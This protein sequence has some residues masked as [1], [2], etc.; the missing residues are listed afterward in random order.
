MFVV[1]SKN[2][3]Y[4]C[5]LLTDESL[6]MVD[7]LIK[8]SSIF[9]DLKKMGVEI[10]ELQYQENMH[11]TLRYMAGD[12]NQ[13]KRDYQLSND[14]LHQV[15]TLHVDGIGAYVKDGVLMNLGLHVDKDES[16]NEPAFSSIRDKLFDNDIAHVTVS[17]NR[18]VDENGKKLTTPVKTSM[19]FMDVGD[20]PKEGEFSYSV[21]LDRPLTLE[22]TAEAMYGET[23]V[24][25]LSDYP[26]ARRDRESGDRDLDID[27]RDF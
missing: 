6:E 26:E 12:R 24:D 27:E 9:E 1:G 8:E 5:G 3:I 25:S 16:M 14:E 7:K 2:V 22:C 11:C 13:S 4:D 23:R 17:V 19:C 15:G 20:N 18:D 10:P 21:K